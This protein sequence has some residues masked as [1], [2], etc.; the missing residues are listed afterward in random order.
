MKYDFRIWFSRCSKCPVR[1][2]KSV[3]FSKLLA[4]LVEIPNEFALGAFR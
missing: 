3:N 1:E 2:D 4:I